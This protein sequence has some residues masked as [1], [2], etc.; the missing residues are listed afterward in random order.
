MKKCKLKHNQDTISNW[1]NWNRLFFK[2]IFRVSKNSTRL[3]V[4]AT[5]GKNVYL[6]VLY[7]K[8]LLVCIKRNKNV[9][10]FAPVVL[11]I[12]IG[13]FFSF[14]PSMSP[15][16]PFW[17]YSMLS[18]GRSLSSL[19]FSLLVGFSQWKHWKEKRGQKMR[20]L[21]TSTSHHLIPHCCHGFVSNFVP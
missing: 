15:L 13:W 6:W 11:R 14:C 20:D 16:H 4:I 2:L 3:A 17:S 7:E 1:Q 8:K 10:L 12:G 5:A 19:A 21:G 9:Y 18:R